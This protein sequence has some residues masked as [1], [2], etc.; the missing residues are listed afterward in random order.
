MGNAC[1]A[2]GLVSFISAVLFL[3]NCLLC[4]LYLVKGKVEKVNVG[5]RL[6]GFLSRLSVEGRLRASGAEPKKAKLNIVFGVEMRSIWFNLLI[7]FGKADYLI[8]PVIPPPMKRTAFRLSTSP[9]IPVINW[10][11]LDGF[12]GAGTENR[13]V[14]GGSATLDTS[15]EGTAVVARRL[16]LLGLRGSL[17]WSRRSQLECLVWVGKIGGAGGV[18]DA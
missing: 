17:Q 13:G 1:S 12:L 10:G 6:Q 14:A 8:S 2:V 5:L 3:E 18:A 4:S 15:G 11:V 16:W 9:P 7:L